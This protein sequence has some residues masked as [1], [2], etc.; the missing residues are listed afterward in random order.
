M[1]LTGLDFE[2]CH[3]NRRVPNQVQPS[4]GTRVMYEC[5][6]ICGKVYEDWAYTIL[7]GRSNCG[8]ENRISIG[9]ETVRNWLDA[10]NIKY[11]TQYWFDDLRGK[12]NMPF[13]F[14]F[15]LLNEDDTLKALIEYQGEQHYHETN[16][17][18]SGFGEYQR[19]VSDP[20]KREYCKKIN[21]PLFEIAYNE[22]TQQKCEEIY[23]LLYH[24]DTVPSE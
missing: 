3:V 13:Y 2:Y 19:E 17:S 9:E 16:K 24:E 8:S 15:S 4:G 23:N 20:L 12:R 21:I 18:I 1:D 7:H 11:T 6:C 10:K 22:N 5:T 14:D